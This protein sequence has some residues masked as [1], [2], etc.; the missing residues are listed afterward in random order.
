[1]R[2]KYGDLLTTLLLLSFLSVKMPK[3]EGSGR[4]PTTICLRI[5]LMVYPFTQT[6][7]N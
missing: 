4:K 3:R 5:L 1:M 2:F 6:D 7:S